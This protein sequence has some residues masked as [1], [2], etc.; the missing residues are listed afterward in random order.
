MLEIVDQLNF[1]QIIKEDMANAME[2]LGDKLVISRV[3][4]G[5]PIKHCINDDYIA[6]FIKSY[7]NEA[8]L[9][10]KKHH[11]IYEQNK[12]ENWEKYKKKYD[13]WY[14]KGHKKELEPPYPYYHSLGDSQD[15]I[16]Y[17]VNHYRQKF[18]YWEK[19]KICE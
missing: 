9:K 1:L 2:I 17:K 4:E 16:E 3:F 8:C 13:R 14:K 6:S 19:L 18:W 10:A 5:I 12:S 15:F 11:E 7:I